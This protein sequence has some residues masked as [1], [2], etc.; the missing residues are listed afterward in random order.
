MKRREFIQK[1][2]LFTGAASISGMSTLH[3]NTEKKSIQP[4]KIKAPRLKK[5]DT[6]GLVTPAGYIS[7]RMLEEAVENM[8]S[9]GFKTYYTAN[10]LD[11]YGYLAGKDDV[12]AGDLNH[13]FELIEGDTR[14]ELIK[15]L[16]KKTLVNHLSSRP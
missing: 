6:V 4:S 1:S 15:A 14:M 11:K 13:M 16:A 9:L 7:E 5:G 8:E 10:I 2:T 12:R 3:A